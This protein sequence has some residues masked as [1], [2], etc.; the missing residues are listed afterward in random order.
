MTKI[1]LSLFLIFLFFAN[2]R[3]SQGQTPG[4]AAGIPP[5]I[6][7]ISYHGNNLWNPG[8]NAGV[9]QLWSVSHKANKRSQPVVIEKFFNADFGFFR[10]YSRQT[11]FFTHVGINNRRY[12]ENKNSLH[13]QFG[14]SP[15]G[16]YR[17][18]LPETWEYTVNGTVE[19]VL[20]PSRWYYAP[21]VSLGMGRFHR[22]Q[23][24]TGW[25]VEMNITTL[26]PYNTYVMPL[27]NIKAGYRIPLNK[28][29]INF[30]TT[31]DHVNN[32]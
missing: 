30:K 10:D 29:F 32:N 22:N 13:F 15:V 25:F 8:L 3:N 17:A 24:G 1:V 20:L 21:A 19:K 7:N 14:F 11:P 16:I 6:F 28:Q 23:P 26:M 5:A 12:R 31:S 4:S 27:L 9:E 18:F 2:V